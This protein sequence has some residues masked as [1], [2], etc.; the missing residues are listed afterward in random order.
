M[1]LKVKDN[2]TKKKGLSLTRML[3]LLE[4]GF[5]QTYIAKHFLCSKANICYHLRKATQNG[6]IQRL[7]Y[8]I[9]NISL[10]IDS[11]KVKDAHTGEVIPLLNETHKLE[12]HH[13]DF[14]LKLIKDNDRFVLGNSI[15]LNN[16][17][18]YQ[19]YRMS[20]GVVIRKYTNR[21]VVI[22]GIRVESDCY[23][24][25]I[26]KA[27]SSAEQYKQ[28]L[29][30]R[31]R[32]I[33]SKEMTVCKQ[34]DIVPHLPQELKNLVQDIAKEGKVEADT[35]FTIDESEGE[36]KGHAEFKLSKIDK[37]KQK[38]AIKKA[39]LMSNIPELLSLL[40]EQQV[41]FSA[42]LMQHLDIL[43]KMSNS[44]DEFNKNMVIMNEK[45]ARL[46]N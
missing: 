1:A 20:N 2:G 10:I 27:T 26:A 5:T 30:K 36:G 39:E 3:L 43:T 16:G 13:L 19:L 44:L 38:E 37:S 4:Q 8:S 42:N 25:A 22:Q 45:L 28:F 29:E 33:F 6:L 18:S 14:K 11:N 23:A 24:N 40:L 32:V 41:C 15:Q 7:P 35:G 31:Y 17:A 21:T 46:G 12:L 9:G 34:P